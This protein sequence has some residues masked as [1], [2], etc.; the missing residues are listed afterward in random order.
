MAAAVASAS[1]ARTCAIAQHT[2]KKTE[3]GSIRG[4]LFGG[5]GLEEACRSLDLRPSYNHYSTT[6]PPKSTHIGSQYPPDTG[7]AL[8]ILLQLFPST[9]RRDA[10][11]A[12]R[13][14]AE[15]AKKKKKKKLP[16]RETNMDFVQDRVENFDW[17]SQKAR[18]RFAV[19]M[20][21]TNVVRGET[22][23]LKTGIA[24]WRSPDV[25]AKPVAEQC[26]FVPSSSLYALPFFIY[27]S[28]WLLITNRQILFAC[29]GQMFPLK[30]MQRSDAVVVAPVALRTCWE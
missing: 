11:G 14:A 1:W 10:T 5:R 21:L 3:A 28:Y 20:L 17:S 12:A 22:G 13:R 8:G 16:R 24:I 26:L 4:V 27:Y 2:R 23:E 7:G 18:T 30:A 25:D 15:E 19:A 9:E 29:L 6:Q